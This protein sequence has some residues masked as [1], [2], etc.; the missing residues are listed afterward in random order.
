MDILLDNP[1]ATMYGPYFLI[2]Y[3]FFIFFVLAFLGYAKTRLDQTNLLSVP[4][5][6]FEIDPYEIAFLRGG[7]HEMTRA[8]VF[9]LVQKD[10]AEIKID[11]KTGSVKRLNPEK[12]ESD[13]SPIE[14]LALQWLGSSRKTDKFFQA[15]GLSAQ[16][17]GYAR[18]FQTRLEMRQILVDEEAKNR[19]TRYK[20]AA[21]SA[22]FLLGVYKLIASVIHGN[23]NFFGIIVLGAIGI[24]TAVVIGKTPR[25]TKLGKAFLDRLQLAFENLKYQSQAPYIAGQK[26]ATPPAKM[27][28]SSVDPLVLSVGVFGSGILTGTVFDSYNEA[29]RR[30]QQQNTLGSCGSGCGSSCSS[31]DGGGS[32]CGGGC[33]GCGGGD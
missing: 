8:V 23:F 6:P 17:D 5:I 30:S 20:R 21:V 31:S 19:L 32:S 11:G 12:S 15:N 29:F 22:V 24:V 25:V 26:A 33:G 1:L 18:T 4:P 7:D 28:S 16:L 14:H 27:I 9:G 10:F 3:G 2:F 13:L